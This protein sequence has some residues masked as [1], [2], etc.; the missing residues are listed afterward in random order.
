MCG[1]LGAFNTTLKKGEKKREHSIKAEDVNEFIITQYQNQ[2]E[3]GQKGFGIIRIDDKGNVECD[4]ACEPT[5]FMLD[6]YMKQAKMIIAHHRTPTS[7]DNTMDQ[8]HP[9]VVSND[10]LSHDYLVIHNGMLSNDAELRDKHKELGFEYTTEYTEYVGYTSLTKRT[11]WN[12]SEALAI[13]VAL[14]IENKIT[15]IGTENNAAFIALQINKKTQKAER[16]YFGRNGQHS[17]LN[18][19]KTR[20]KLR[21][22]SEGEGDEVKTNILYSFDTKDPI[23]DL[24]SKKMPFVKKEIPKTV[25]EIVKEATK[26][27]LTNSSVTKIETTTTTATT[28]PTTP[29]LPN[30]ENKRFIRSWIKSEE[31]AEPDYQD[32]TM[33]SEKSYSEEKEKDIKELLKDSSTGE[34]TH[35]IDDSLDEE[36]EKIADLVSNFKNILLTDKLE[37]GEEMYYVDQI[38]VILKAMAKMADTA[39]EIYLEKDIEEI[40]EDVEIGRELDTKDTDTNF[41][42]LSSRRRE[43]KENGVHMGFAHEE[44]TGY[45]G[46]NP[47]VY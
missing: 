44:Y 6:L 31:E 40:Q 7:T 17:C 24:K 12:D 16:V 33:Y 41:D 35:Q 20:G 38:S 37:N 45:R 15:A 14:F 5:K 11:K 42:G 32:L 36:L 27:M 8:T 46:Y 30:M 21:L 43:I 23:M 1:I 2:Y 9:M 3:R 18:M 28:T 34:I 47:D 4:R 10:L 39:D 19:S 29:T 13:E 25:S 22:S 26:L